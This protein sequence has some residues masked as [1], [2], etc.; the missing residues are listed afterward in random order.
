MTPLLCFALV[1]AVGSWLH[2]NT[3][4]PQVILRRCA[5]FWGYAILGIGAFMALLPHCAITMSQARALLLVAIFFTGTWALDHGEDVVVAAARYLNPPRAPIYYLLGA[6]IRYGAMT[7]MVTLGMWTAYIV[8]GVPWDFS[9]YWATGVAA[10]P[11]AWLLV[12][13]FGPDVGW[14]LFE[15]LIGALVL[16]PL[17][18][19]VTR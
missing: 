13:V 1:G 19:V 11:L 8:T 9:W 6:S 3:T 4:T 16:G 18:Y 5:L 17:P 15:P 10:G 7:A 12:R 2:A 14:K